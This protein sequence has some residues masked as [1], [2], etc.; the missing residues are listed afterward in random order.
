MF[1]I[2]D[3][4]EQFMLGMRFCIYPFL[5]KMINEKNKEMTLAEHFNSC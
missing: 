2:N 5:L 1:R 3:T 4:P